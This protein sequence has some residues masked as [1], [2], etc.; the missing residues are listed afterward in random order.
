MKRFV[1][2]AA[3]ALG[4]SVAFLATSAPAQQQSPSKKPTTTTKK[5]G[6]K[7]K[8][9]KPVGKPVEMGDLDEPVAAPAPPPGPTGTASTGSTATS[10][11]SA[12]VSASGSASSSA[13]AS[14]T[15][16]AHDAKSDVEAP[17][18][19][20]KDDRD[21]RDKRFSA[22]LL[23]GVGIGNARPCGGGTCNAYGLGFGLRGGYEITHHL[24]VGGAFV[25][26]L[27]FSRAIPVGPFTSQQSASVLYFGPE[28]GYNIDAGPIVIR[29]YLGIGLGILSASV[30]S[31]FGANGTA[32]DTS[33]SGAHFAL[34][35]GVT[36]LYPINQTFF[37]GADLRF[38]IVGENA[39][40]LF[41]TGG[42]RF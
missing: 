2:R 38:A 27:G 1:T 23:V 3:A 20:P 18:P 33:G 21:A 41:A 4:L 5:K 12:S 34:W 13:A 14:P 15:S 16:D 7:K 29:P 35:P 28:L 40:S 25:Y 31:G 11:G 19:T 26:H 36:G 42:L 17:G 8:P 37:A 6:G 24:Y 30:T 22:A 39:L 10:S 32:A 9:K